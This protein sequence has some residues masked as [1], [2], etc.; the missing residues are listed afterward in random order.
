M[1]TKRQLV[2]ASTPQ[3]SAG[4]NRRR[5]SFFFSSFCR[6]VHVGES[7]LALLFWRESPVS[8][9]DLQ[10]RRRKQN[11]CFISWVERRSRRDPRQNESTLMIFVSFYKF[12]KYVWFVYHLGIF[13]WQRFIFKYEIKMINYYHVLLEFFKQNELQLK[14][15]SWRH[16]RHVS[17]KGLFFYSV[18]NLVVY[19]QADRTFGKADDV[20][21]NT[22]QS[23]CCSRRISGRFKPDFYTLWALK[24]PQVQTVLRFVHSIRSVSLCLQKHSFHKFARLIWTNLCKHKSHNNTN[25]RT[26]GGS[27]RRVVW[28]KT[29]FC[30]K[31]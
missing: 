25:P 19:L 20:N 29:S 3:T 12:C 14:T 5:R 21:T 13:I 1:T 17:I 7:P 27:G 2:S 6:I 28:R 15:Q 16:R 8:C 10:Q 30:Q 24:E 18:I 11:V 23:H 22:L 31:Q 26:D 9:V 4:Q